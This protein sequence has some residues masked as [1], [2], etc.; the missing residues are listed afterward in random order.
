MKSCASNSNNKQEAEFESMPR[1]PEESTY[2]RLLALLTAA[3]KAGVISGASPSEVTAALLLAGA[4]S[5]RAQGVSSTSFQ[6]LAAQIYQTAGE[7]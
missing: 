4:Q 1:K 7:G 6:D 5:A 3:V 2:A